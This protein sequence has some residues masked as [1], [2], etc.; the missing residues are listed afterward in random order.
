MGRVQKILAQVELPERDKHNC[1]VFIDLAESVHI[2][3]REHR[4]VFDTDE[5]FAVTKAFTEAAEKLEDRIISGYK[6]GTNYSTEIIGGKQT[7]PMNIKTPH[8][9]LFNNRMV[10]EKNYPDVI[11]GIHIHYRDYRLVM[12]NLETFRRFCECVKEAQISLDQ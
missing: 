9:S 7:E 2:H 3:Y 5:F 12:D 8:K 1:R 4:L 6:I 11:D 10:I